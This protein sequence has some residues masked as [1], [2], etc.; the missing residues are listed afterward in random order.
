MSAITET[1]PGQEMVCIL[2]FEVRPR[3]GEGQPNPGP[4]R[5][6]SVGEY[7]R[8]VSHF[9]VSKPEDNP[10]GYMAV[11]QPIDPK[12]NNKYEA[13]QD[14]FVSLDCWEALNEYFASSLIVTEIGKSRAKKKHSY[15]LTQIKGNPARKSTDKGREI[16]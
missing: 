10:I 5:A 6:F 9:F 13:T 12:D 2:G 1:E 14:Y 7:V 16:R 15:K 11:F 8:Y 3:I 4:Y